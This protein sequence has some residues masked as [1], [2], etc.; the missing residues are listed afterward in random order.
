MARS[1]FSENRSSETL[2]LLPP[3]PLMSPFFEA[4]WLLYRRRPCWAS[5]SMQ[6][7][8]SL[9]EHMRTG[10]WGG[11]GMEGN[12]PDEQLT[13]LFR[14]GLGIFLRGGMLS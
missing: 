10:E 9:S 12:G 8:I 13:Q 1:G 11:Q 5:G 2:W 3:F 6:G 14:L 7:L 4:L